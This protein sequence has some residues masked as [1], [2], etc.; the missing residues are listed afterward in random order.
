MMRVRPPAVAGSFYPAR[1]AQ[2]QQAV[3]A[4]LA[5]A[6]SAAWPDASQPKALIVPHAGYVYSGPTAAQAYQ[7]LAPH[8]ATI[9]RVVL[10]GPVHHVPVRGLALPTAQAFATPLGEVP[11]DAAAVRSLADL[12]QVVYGDAAHAQEHALEVQLPFLQTALDHFTLLP[13]AVG[14]ASP[15]Q[16]AQVLDRIWGGAE[17][18]LVI[19]SDLSHGLPYQQAQVQDQAT[20]E[21][22]LHP[23]VFLNHQQAC[24]ATPVNGLLL[25]ASA[26]GLQAHLLELCN[27]GDTAG[28]R[29]QVVGYAALAFDRE[30]NH[31]H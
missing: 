25:A 10:L 24:G 23:S 1:A 28:D 9:T 20:V 7:L 22:M 21:T 16:V 12:P 18:L 29:S 26:H 4:L 27:S 2:L 31:V 8:R 14:A 3:E 17:T 19:S 5:R 30:T 15:E 11:I 6:R 13:L